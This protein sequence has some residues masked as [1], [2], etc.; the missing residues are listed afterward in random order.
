MYFIFKSKYGGLAQTDPVNYPL[1]RSTGLDIGDTG[2]MDW[3]FAV[4]TVIGLIATFFLPWYDDPL[5]YTETY[6]IEGLFDILISCI[7][8]ITAASGVLTV[9]LVI[10]ARKV[11]PKKAKNAWR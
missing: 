9:I 2:R 6:G 1:N 8:W 10:I 11:E 7:R 5:Y 3:L 4:M